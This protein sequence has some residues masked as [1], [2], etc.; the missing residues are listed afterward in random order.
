MYTIC[1]QAVATKVNIIK[2]GSNVLQY[3]PPS[4]DDDTSPN[5]DYVQDTDSCDAVVVA[6][7]YI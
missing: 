5:I 1:I 3:K 6:S 2:E 4:D 7:W